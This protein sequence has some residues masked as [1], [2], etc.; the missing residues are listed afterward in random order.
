MG[1]FYSKNRTKYFVYILI[2]FIFISLTLSGLSSNNNDISFKFSHILSTQY[3][4]EILSLEQSK[5]TLEIIFGI[6]GL[7]FLSL[8][9][10]CN[11]VQDSIYTSYES[12]N[13]SK[14]YK[15]QLKLLLLPKQNSSKYKS[16]LNN[17]LNQQTNIKEALQWKHMKLQFGLLSFYLL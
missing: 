12:F 3:Q 17:E 9:F 6:A 8:I 13:I 14:L 10:K 2:I 16:Y 1:C 5:I 4:F 15:I 7:F 11:S